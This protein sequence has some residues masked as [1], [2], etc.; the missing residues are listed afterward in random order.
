MGPKQVSLGLSLNISQFIVAKS[1]ARVKT[2]YV[3]GA[4]RNVHLKFLHSSLYTNHRTCHFT[5]GNP[6][7]S[8]CEQNNVMVREDNMHVFLHCPIAQRF[9][10]RLTSILQKISGVARL[11][12]SDFVLG[13]YINKRQKHICFNFLILH[14]H[15]ALWKARCK[16]EQNSDDPPLPYVILKE[17]VFRNLCRVKTILRSE[18]FYHTFEDLVSPSSTPIG[19][20][21][22]L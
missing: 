12:N 21:T 17:E 2:K 13:R 22:T 8:N 1:W 18:V 6:Y 10:Q 5:D 9:Y 3:D 7:C 15:L 19:F 4:A 14:A 11:T 20:R 16:F